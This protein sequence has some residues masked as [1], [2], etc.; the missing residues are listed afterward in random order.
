MGG[1][2]ERLAEGGV[3]LR[4]EDSAAVAALPQHGLQGVVVEAAVDQRAV[5]VALVG[6]DDLVD[7]AAPEVL[8]FHD[9][10]GSVV[11][12]LQVF[13]FEV[14]VLGVGGIGVGDFADAV[15]G[16]VVGGDGFQVAVVVGVRF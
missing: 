13:A 3:A 6:V 4:G 11:G 16:R 5:A 7:D 14:V 8:G 1:L 10:A 2:G 15:A 12:G 9:A